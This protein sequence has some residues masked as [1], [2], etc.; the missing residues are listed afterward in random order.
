MTFRAVKVKP[1]LTN[2]LE[3]LGI[4]RPTP[5]Q[6]ACILLIIEGRNDAASAKR[7]TGK[8]ATFFISNLKTMAEDPY[9]L[10]MLMV[11]HIR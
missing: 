2:A 7:D 6:Q 5:V 11:T 8:T 9:G 4:A 10:F 3:S 1:C